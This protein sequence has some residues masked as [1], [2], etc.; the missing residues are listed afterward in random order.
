[1]KRKKSDDEI[2]AE[3]LKKDEN[4]RRLH[5]KVVELNGG[6]LP[7]SEEM[8]HRLVERVERGRRAGL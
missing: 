1:M 8:G 3:L 2:T 6:R 5:D 4:F 7:T